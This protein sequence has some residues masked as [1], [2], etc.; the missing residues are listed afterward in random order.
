MDKLDLEFVSRL[1]TELSNIAVEENDGRLI[2]TLPFADYQG[3]PVEISA[4]VTQDHAEVDDLGR[5]AG[6]LFSMDQHHEDTPA[7]GLVKNLTDAYG[8]T[9]DFDNGL[10][11]QTISTGTDLR[12][13]LD[14]I[15]SIIALQVATPELK[16]VKPKRRRSGLISRIGDDIRKLRPP[17]ELDYQTAVWGKNECWT[18]PWRYYKS[19]AGGSE[20]LIYTADLFTLEPRDKASTALAMA[21]DFMESKRPVDFRVVYEI[22]EDT[23]IAEMQ[24]ARNLIDE[25]QDKLKYAAFNYANLSHRDRFINAAEADMV[26]YTG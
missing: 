9:M 17:F 20:V 2:I 18:I 22:D 24:R 23:K 11:K 5:I 14:Y 1:R 26:A 7:F 15:K 12:D 21:L 3:D 4:F 19:K 16:R 13:F 25:H 10:I 8:I 6:L